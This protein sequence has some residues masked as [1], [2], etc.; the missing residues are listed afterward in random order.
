M[1]GIIYDKVISQPL[2]S[3]SRPLSNLCFT[4]I[5]MCDEALAKDGA[6]KRKNRP[7]GSRNYIILIVLKLKKVI[8]IIQKVSR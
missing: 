7:L 6:K 1:L 2:P 8:I 5:S 3:I 4:N